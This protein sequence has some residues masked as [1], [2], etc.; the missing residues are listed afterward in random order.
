MILT[1]R[2]SAAVRQEVIPV[3]I[4]QIDAGSNIGI[5]GYAR[6]NLDFNKQQFILGDGR[7][8]DEAVR[9]LAQMGK[10]TSFCTADYRCGRTGGCFMGIAKQGKIHNLCMP[11]A[12]LT[13]K[14]YL[15]DYASEETKRAGQH[16]IDDE[17]AAIE[18]EAVR[19][20]CIE[21]LHRIEAGER[22]LYF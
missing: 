4:T 5:G 21:Y 22:D 9:D 3:G 7:S 19:Q 12:V 14:E 10:I 15:L 16:L 1:A 8:L 13:F 20:K 17:L 2:E 18:N 6:D 11:N